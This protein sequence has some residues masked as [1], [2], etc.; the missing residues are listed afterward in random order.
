M[1]QIN[2]ITGAR[3]LTTGFPNGA[4]NVPIWLDNLLCVG[5]ETSLFSCRKN[6]VG[7]HNCAHI[8]DAG[9]VCQPGM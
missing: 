4:T 9:V 7:S 5:S 2:I 6:A 1:T 3:S 8:E